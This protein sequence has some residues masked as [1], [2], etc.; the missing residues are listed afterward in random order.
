MPLFATHG[1]RADVLFIIIALLGIALPHGEDNMFIEH[2]VTAAHHPTGSRIVHQPRRG[3]GSVA[4]KDTLPRA[5]V[6][7]TALRFV[8][9]DIG[10]IAEDPYRAKISSSTGRQGD[11]YT[12]G[13]ATIH[14]IADMHRSGHR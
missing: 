10:R 14:T 4:H 8:N 3:F 13:S 1:A 11:M 5:I 6:K 2:H 7:F 9:V 12:A